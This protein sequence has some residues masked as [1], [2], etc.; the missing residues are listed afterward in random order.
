MTSSGPSTAPSGAS[1]PKSAPQ[2]HPSEAVKEKKDLRSWWK[3]FRDGEKKTQDQGTLYYGMHKGVV[4]LQADYRRL[5]RSHHLS[6]A[7]FPFGCFSIAH[8]T[9]VSDVLS[10]RGSCML[11]SRRLDR[12]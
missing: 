8:D 3:S 1:G 5:R 4:A 10:P 7:C 11:A 2:P 12:V 9:F 6:L